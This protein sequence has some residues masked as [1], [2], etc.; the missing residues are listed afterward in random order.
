MVEKNWSITVAA[1][2]Q[3]SQ[4]QMAL[5]YVKDRAVSDVDSVQIAPPLLCANHIKVHYSVRPLHRHTNTSSSHPFVPPNTYETLSQKPH[6]TQTQSWRCA[7]NLKIP[8]SKRTCPTKKDG[9]G[10]LQRGHRGL[11]QQSFRVGVFSTLTNSYALV[12]VGAS[13]NFYR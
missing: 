4:A 8:T 2:S 3:T 1:M 12:A 5:A 10:I 6:K 11:T 9:L 13:E 7:H